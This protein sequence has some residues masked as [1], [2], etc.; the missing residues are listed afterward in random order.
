MK[1]LILCSAAFHGYVHVQALCIADDTPYDL[2]MPNPGE[3]TVKS[4]I[5]E[6]GS[7]LLLR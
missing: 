1:F 3:V 7:S 2:S 6:V 5:D 4:I